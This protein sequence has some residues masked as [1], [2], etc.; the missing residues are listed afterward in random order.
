QAALAFGV[1]MD[2]D[3]VRRILNVHY[4]PDADSGDPSRLTFLGHTKD[5]LWSCD[6]LRC[7]SATLTTHW[8]LVMVMDH[9][10]SHRRVWRPPWHHGR[11]WAVPDVPTSDPRA[12]S[13]KVP[14]L[15]S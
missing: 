2:G 5:S 11:R 6:L 13:P 1:D 9:Y 4:R 7:A 15:R 12:K 14:R 3:V 10:T 8:V